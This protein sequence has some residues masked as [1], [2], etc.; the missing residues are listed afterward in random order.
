[1]V[2][3]GFAALALSAGAGVAAA[4]PDANT[5]VNTTCSYDQIVRAI[6]AEVPGE[7]SGI[8]NNSRL[9]GLLRDFVAAPA[10]ERRSMLQ[11]A[12]G[13]FF[14][15]DDVGAMIQVADSCNNY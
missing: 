15:Q 14:L 7:A 9:Q 10:D 3:A 12:M 8:N 1:M 4:A 13:S 6:N 11:Q 5:L 2:A